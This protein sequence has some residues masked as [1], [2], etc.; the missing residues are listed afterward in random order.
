VAEAVGLEDMMHAITGNITRLCYNVEPELLE[1]VKNQTWQSMLSHLDGSTPVFEDIG[2]Q[3][4]CYGR[5]LHP[6]EIYNRINAVDGN[7]VRAAAKRFFHDRDHALAAIGPI[8]E[9]PDYNW[10]RR[11][12][13]FLRF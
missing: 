5:R 1:E 2:R 6:S 13:Y 10:I 8:W 7:A 3:V 9:L 11:R 4:L 12:S